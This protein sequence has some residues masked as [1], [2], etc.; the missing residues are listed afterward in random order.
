MKCAIERDA[1]S[2]ARVYWPLVVS[3]SHQVS[4]INAI[5]PAR[6]MGKTSIGTAPPAQMMLSKTFRV[7]KPGAAFFRLL[8]ALS[9]KTESIRPCVHNGRFSCDVVAARDW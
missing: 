2:A 7:A 3:S 6:I 5:M 1:S 4:T 9:S 8:G